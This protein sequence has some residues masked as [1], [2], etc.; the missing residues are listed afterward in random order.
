MAAITL[1][2]P[3]FSGHEDEDIDSFIHLF[4]GYLNA[5]NLNP[6]GN[7]ARYIGIFRACLK[8]EHRSNDV[9]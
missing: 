4:L 5:I 1:G 3:T 7:S 9:K 2:L 8:G 6:V